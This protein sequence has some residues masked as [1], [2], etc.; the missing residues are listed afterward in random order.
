ML[1]SLQVTLIN[2][3]TAP[4]DLRER[5]A[6]QLGDG[7]AEAWR[8]LEEVSSETVVLGTCNRMEFYIRS[9]AAVDVLARVGGSLARELGD[10]SL[11]IRG[12]GVVQHLYEVAS[13]LD[14]MVVGET[15]ILGQVREAYEEAIRRQRVGRFFHPLFQGALRAA[16]D[17]HT[18]TG[19]G[20]GH[21]SIGSVAVDLCRQV[22]SKLEDRHCVILGAGTMAQLAASSLRDAGVR[23]LEICSRTL[24]HA[25]ALAR[26]TGGRA[27]AWEEWPAS[28]ERADILMTLVTSPEAF[29]T[30]DIME[31]TQDVRRHRPLLAVDM[32]LPRNIH[33]DVDNVRGVYRHDMDS[34]QDIMEDNVRGRRELM[35]AAQ[36]RIAGHV[37]ELVLKLEHPESAEWNKALDEKA[38]VLRDEEL[39]R[40]RHRLPEA[41]HGLLLESLQR[42]GNK[43]M[44]PIRNQPPSGEDSASGS[45]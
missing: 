23:S 6:R 11:T 25:Q 17:V 4:L 24:E 40:L 12:P 36:G 37:A 9:D 44:H 30:R 18:H 27:T 28:L 1:D 16:K 10:H 26:D 41:Y 32:S 3:K 14:S 19:L 13:S 31:R 42:Y 20:R 34:L 33:P 2:H 29:V 21:V 15:Q 5:F 35:E 22:W 45:T 7:H 38:R 39:N 8:L 43:L